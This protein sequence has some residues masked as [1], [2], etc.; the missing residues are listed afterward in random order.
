[1]S[2][3]PEPTIQLEADGFFFESFNDSE[4]LTSEKNIS[5]P[6][7]MEA[8]QS[9]VSFPDEKSFNPTFY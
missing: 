2:F 7:H 9:D 6:G 8:M 5:S 1:M 4:S 3:N